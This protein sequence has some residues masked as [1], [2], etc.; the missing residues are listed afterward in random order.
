MEHVHIGSVHVEVVAELILILIL[1]HVRNQD[2]QYMVAFVQGVH[3][4]DLVEKNINTKKKSH[5]YKL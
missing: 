1:I 2:I 4:V 5:N 3:I